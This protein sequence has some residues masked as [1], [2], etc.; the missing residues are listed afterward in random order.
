MLE[1]DVII[2]VHKTRGTPVNQGQTK[3]TDN[4]KPTDGKIP[5]MGHPP[6]TESDLSLKEFVETVFA[7]NAKDENKDNKKGIKLDFKSAE[8]ITKSMDILKAN[9]N[10]RVQI[11]S[12]FIEI[13]HKL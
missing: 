9:Q 1:A 10:V 6:A 7:H 12:K 13:F 8:A 2:G 4:V 11:K 3:T 5:I